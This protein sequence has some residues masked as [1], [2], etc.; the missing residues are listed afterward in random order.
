MGGSEIVCDDAGVI[1]C[2][3]FAGDGGGVG[4]GERGVGGDIDIDSDR[5][6]GADVGRNGGGPDAANKRRGAGGAVPSGAGDGEGD[7][8]AGGQ[9]ITYG[10]VAGTG[11]CADVIDGY[12]VGGGSAL[13]ERWT[14][15]FC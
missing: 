14:R 4:D 11:A 9:V 13:D 1:D 2:I 15:W 7:R 6:R 10:V 5:G 3:E 12:G 8:E